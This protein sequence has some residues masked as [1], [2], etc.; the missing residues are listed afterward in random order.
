MHPY[1]PHL[2]TFDYRGKH[3]YFLTFTTFDRRALFVEERAVSLV[4][5][6]FLR[7]ATEQQFEITTYCFMPDHVHLL[8]MGLGDT[9]CCRRFIKL[10]KQ[11]SGYYFHR[12]RG[13]TLWQRYGYERALRSEIERATTIRYILDNPVEAGLAQEPGD[14][15]FVGSS[16]FSLP[17]L[18]QQAARRG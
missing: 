18:V 13:E 12:H 7:A 11:Y 8:V 10:A 16:C 2:K 15:P 17:E 9:S 5:Q 4:L 14:Y 3:S 6:Q 1:P